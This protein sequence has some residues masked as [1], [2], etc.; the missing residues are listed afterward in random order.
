M[1]VLQSKLWITFGMLLVCVPGVWAQPQNQDQGQSQSQS[2]SQNQSQPQDQSQAPIPAY[3][4]PLG[5]TTDKG[6][7]SSGTDLTPDTS[8][9]RE[10]RISRWD[11]RNPI[12]TANQR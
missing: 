2:Q 9:W 6:N 5:T 11:S 3:H 10:R 4:S 8:R 1:S 7:A 12:A